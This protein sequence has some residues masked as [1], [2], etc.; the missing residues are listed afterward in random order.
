MQYNSIVFCLK[1]PTEVS[2]DL[3]FSLYRAHVTIFTRETARSLLLWKER[4][5]GNNVENN[6]K[7]DE[8]TILGDLGKVSYKY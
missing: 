4:N 3:L 1:V 7:I 5:F 2:S 8:N 6:Y